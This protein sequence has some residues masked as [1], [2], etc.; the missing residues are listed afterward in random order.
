MDSPVPPGG[1]CLLDIP[2]VARRLRVSPK[3]IRR[4][5][6]RGELAA[7]AVG[8]LIRVEVD[9][10]EKYITMRRIAPGER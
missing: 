1:K 9:E 10:V 3:P 2:A 8:R 5:I 7:I 4:K 6:K